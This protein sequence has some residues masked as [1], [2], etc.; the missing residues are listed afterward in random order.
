[1]QACGTCVLISRYALLIITFVMSVTTACFAQ[2]TPVADDGSN[3]PAISLGQTFDNWLTQ[4]TMSG[5][6][7]GLRTRLAQDGFNFRGSYIG[8]YAYSFSGGKR[9]GGDYAQ[10]W[11]VGVDVDMEKVV[12]IPGGTFHFS[13]NVRE[14]RSTSADYIGNKIAVQE[15]YG[16]GENPRLAEVSYQQLLFDKLLD[17][18][19][20][21]FA[22]GDD[23]GRT[24]ILCDF[25]N[26][27]FCAHPVSLPTNSG[28]SDYPAGKWGLR[29]RVNLT[30]DFYAETGVFEVNPTY[31]AHN[32]GFKLSLDGSTG[33][34]V[35]IEFAKTVALGTAGMPGHYKIGAYFDS[36]Q[37]PDITD[38]TLKYTGRYGAYVLVD[39]M[40]WTFAPGHDRGLIAVANATISDARTAQIPTYFTFALIAQGPFD[41]RPNDY[42][43]IGYVRDNVN[44]RAI[45]QE[46]DLLAA[47]GVSN[48]ELELGENNVELAY[49]FQAT[50]WFAIH[51]NVQFVGN[52]GA[53]TFKQIPNAW[54][55]GV[56]V[57][58]TF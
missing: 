15:I 7:G 29:A 42:I 12:G 28:W 34:L 33:V 45:R 1:M 50:P 14:G 5:D 32:N 54:V 52:P 3:A 44:G 19:V 25:Q 31:S 11:A 23:F 39:Q 13:L 56:H 8:E 17:L 57:G 24:A 20:G 6:W 55:F 4:P 49:G 35:P 10:Q 30:D 51:P 40:V 53:F 27:S 9:I 48:P 16:D 26:D 22:M 46:Q 18:K 43:A 47:Q 37:A 2:T 38:P 58:L 21:F 36:S 41:V